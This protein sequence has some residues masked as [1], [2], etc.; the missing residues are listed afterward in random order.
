M[1][2][3]SE[4]ARVS[5]GAANRSWRNYLLDPGFQLKY[6]GM[7]VLVTLVVASVLGFAAYRFSH[8]VTE[9]NLVAMAMDPNVDPAVLDSM[10]ATV[11]EY[12]RKVALSIVAGVAF[13]CLALGITGIIVTHKVVGPAYKLRMLLEHLANGRMELVGRLRPGDELQHVFLSLKA[14]VDAWRTIQLEEISELEAGIEAARRAGV[15]EAQ[16]ESILRVRDRM[17]HA[18]GE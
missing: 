14:M 11:S 2:A 8:S 1:S 10:T 3:T 16:L 12:D 5:H 9:M 7:V 4:T 17:K 6:T 15:T 18:I 13:L